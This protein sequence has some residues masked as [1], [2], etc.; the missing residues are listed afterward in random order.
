M[1]SGERGL[2]R[3][4]DFQRQQDELRVGRIR[5]SLVLKGDEFCQDCGDEIGAR[6]RAALPSATR[7]VDCQAGFER[8][9]RMSR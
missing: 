3:A 8:D 6:R 1:M 5:S 7:C 9:R 2:E 4:E